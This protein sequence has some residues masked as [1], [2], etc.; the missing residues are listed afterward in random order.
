MERRVKDR[1]LWKYSAS[2]L[3]VGLGVD[4]EMLLELKEVSIFYDTM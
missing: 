4:F 1:K 2:L 3:Q